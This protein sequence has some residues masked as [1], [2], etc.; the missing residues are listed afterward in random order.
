[1][2]LT[3]GVSMSTA[4][5]IKSLA[6]YDLIRDMILSGEAL[7]GTRLVLVDLEKKLGVG[8]GPI[9]D[10]LMRLDK[11][12][13]VQNIPTKCHRHDAALFKEIEHIFNLRIQ[14]ECALAKEA[15]QQA[16]AED[17]D[18]LE[19]LAGDLADTR[20]ADFFFHKDRD[21]HLQLYSLSRMH[22]LL[23]VDSHLLDYVEGFLNT[24]R[25]SP[26]DIS[27]FIQQHKD[28]LTAMR[29]RMKKTHGS[30]APQHPSRPGADAGRD[31]APE[32]P[33]GARFTG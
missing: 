32:A 22:H 16:T 15:M 9:R 8:R 30:H 31:E 12:G 29:E 2:Y 33:L 6:A 24:C 21:F 11:S 17:M 18:R 14:V 7:P 13:L 20:D 28:I 19:Q 1:M 3:E 27:L 26:E 25:Y 23:A 5:T 4:S 10:A